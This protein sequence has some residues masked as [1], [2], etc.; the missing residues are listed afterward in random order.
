ML[1]RQS[2]LINRFQIISPYLSKT[3]R[4]LRSFQDPLNPNLN[5]LVHLITSTLN[6]WPLVR[7]LTLTHLLWFI[8]SLSITIILIVFPEV[9]PKITIRKNNLNEF[10]TR[11][12]KATHMRDTSNGISRESLGLKKCERVSQAIVKIWMNA[13]SNLR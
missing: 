9:L 3:Q 2:I 10:I 6:L 13:P 7:Y 1:D 5:K 8:N 12:S 4:P 11:E